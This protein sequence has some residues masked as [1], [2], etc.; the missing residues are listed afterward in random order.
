MRE[1]E[2]PHIPRRPD[3]SEE[4]EVF[5]SS[6]WCEDMCKLRKWD[7]SAKVVDMDVPRLDAW[8]I[9]IERVLGVERMRYDVRMEI[10]L[11]SNV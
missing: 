6:P 10:D 4:K 5:E 9:V 2:E 8:Q 3:A 11:L 7:D 1:Q